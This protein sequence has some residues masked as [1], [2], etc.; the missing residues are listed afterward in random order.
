MSTGTT[1]LLEPRSSDK[2]QPD[3]YSWRRLTSWVGTA[4]KALATHIAFLIRYDLNILKPLPINPALDIAVSNDRV[5]EQKTAEKVYRIN[6][7]GRVLKRSLRWDEYPVLSDGET[8]VPFLVVE[9]L[10][11]EAACMTYIRENT[12]IPVPKLLDTYK[13]NGSYYL[14]MEFIDGV[15]MS[16]LTGEE[17]S[18]VLPQGKCTVPSLPYCYGIEY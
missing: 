14:W 16:E 11:N 10:Q 6:D 1:V 7:R 3:T 13:E 12:D 17:Q 8:L 5:P 15:E 18:K 2:T 9:R 4:V